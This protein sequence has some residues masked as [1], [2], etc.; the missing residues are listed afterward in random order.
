MLRLGARSLARCTQ[1]HRAQMAGAAKRPPHDVL[2]VSP[3]ASLADVK[4]AY[5]RLATKMHPDISKEPDAHEKFIEIGDAYRMLRERLEQPAAAAPGD[6]AGA[7]STARPGDVTAGAGVAD[8]RYLHSLW[9]DHIARSP[10]ASRLDRLL[11]GH[12]E[13]TLIESL[14][15]GG[16]L[17]SALQVLADIKAQGKRPGQ[18]VFAM[19][20]RGCTLHMK[21]P[22]P[23]TPLDRRDHLTTNLHA[24]AREL[25]AEMQAVHGLRPYHSTIHE[26]IR[27]HGKAGDFDAAYR[28]FI[29][30]IYERHHRPSSLVCNTMLEL[31]AAT[32]RTAAAHEIVSMLH[33]SRALLRAL[34][35]PDAVTFSLAM[36][37]AV[38]GQHFDTLPSQLRMLASC[39]LKPDAVTA[40]RL[41]TAALD[42]GRTRDALAIAETVRAIGARV[43]A[44]IAERLA[45][46]ERLAALARDA[47][48]V[49][50]AEEAR[51][52]AERE[53]AAAALAAKLR[54]MQ[55]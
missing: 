35:R 48:R 12:D 46:A 38:Q 44:P 3:A 40:G 5:Y 4:T 37:N 55:R 31:C 33:G 14:L 50:T 24:K 36:A 43:D 7:T 34:Y 39:H 18:P 26:M 6:G 45:G 53:A 32:G 27:A 54:D 19:L 1:M 22:P 16:D 11:F 47:E 15:R 13:H 21:R 28:L 10:L 49:P 8:N 20:I 42:A 51:A 30:L 52:L 17:A 25:F 23:G 29:A 41:V 9:E 2:G